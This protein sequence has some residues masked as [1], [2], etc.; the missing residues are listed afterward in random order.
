M[1]L[2][3][4]G[5][6]SA[7]TANSGHCSADKTAKVWDART[8]KEVSAL[9]GHGA[10]VTSIA[11]RPLH[12][13][14]FL[15]TGSK[16]HSVRIWD[17]KNQRGIADLFGHRGP[18]TEV[19][20]SPDG[21]LL[22]SSS[23]DGDVRIWEAAS[24][25]PDGPS[26]RLIHVLSGHGGIVHAI[27]FSPDGKRL[28][29]AHEDGTITFW[30]VGTGQEALSLRRQVVNASSVAFSPGGRRLAVGAPPAGTRGSGV[31]IW[32]AEPAAKPAPVSLQQVLAQDARDGLYHKARA[33]SARD[34]RQAISFFSK[35]LD[36]GRDDATILS[37]RGVQFAL[38][39]K[40]SDAAAD[41][42]GAARRRPQDAN[43]WYW[44]AAAQ[45]GEKDVIAY[46]KTRASMLDRF[47]KT[48]DR[49]VA[50][51]VLY[52]CVTLPA[53][54]PESEQMVRLGQ[55][56]SPLFTSN[57]RG[58][59]AALY[60]HGN[61]KAA[62]ERFARSAKIFTP[63]AWDL[64]FRAMAHHQLGQSG[65][66]KAC[67]NEALAWIERT[68][69]QAAAGNRTAWIGWYESI[70]TQFLREEAAA[71]LGKPQKKS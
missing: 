10:G 25:V 44:Q 23:E 28:V 69:H 31:T 61:H 55:T 6:S 43:F 66:A 42:A 16:D 15:A 30:D 71:L 29:S 7:R 3:S 57:D 4:R 19:A 5:L 63:R 56:A 20:F 40:W 54:G 2:R 64:L 67:F 32:E 36:L 33:A 41:F 9:V 37:E 1:P 21:Q 51:H 52:I 60:R 53:T 8:G 39:R 48:T 17:V 38:M 35:A 59:A 26:G 46:Q 47:G 27:T 70:E 45:L 49:A 22:A 62:L 58:L 34:A 12:G 50:G 65:E 11:F 68:N 18:I 14:S 13:G 24:A